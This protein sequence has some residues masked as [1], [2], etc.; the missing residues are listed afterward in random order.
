MGL[1]KN[2]FKQT[3]IY[4]LATVLPRM[5][6]FLLVP[7]Y[8]DLLPK[9]EYGKV[10]IIFAWM[11]FFNVILAY[12]METAFFRF[13]NKEEDKKIVVE[14]SMVSIFWTTIVFLF[15]AL[16]FRTTLADWSGIDSQYIT[17][18]IWILTLDAL[19]IIPFSKLR[20]FQ[21]PM[22]Y[23]IIKIGNVL[24]NLLLS[25]LFLIYLPKMAE[26]NPTGLISSFYIENFQVGYIFLA[27]I[28]ASLLTFV[29]LSPD[30]V[31]LK[32]KFNFSLWK[33]MMVYGLPILVAGIAFAINEQ[34]DKI[35]LDRLLPRNIAEDEVGVYSACYK[36]GLFMVLYRTAYTLGIEPFFFSHAKDENAPQT[37]A[38]VTKYFVIF[39]SFIMLSVIVFADLFKFIMIRDESY[40]VAMKVVPLIILANFCL[41]IYTNLSVWYKLID[42]TYIGAYISIVGA[43]I[44]LV[45]NF[46]LIPSMSYTGSA[47]A[48][49]AAYGSMMLISY[50]LGNKYYPIPYDFNKIGGYLGL[51]VIF[52]VVSFYGFRENYFVG[53][54]LLLLFLYFIYHNEKETLMSIMNRKSNQKK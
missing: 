52:S 19:V 8:T 3:A 38:M 40:W 28:I 21:R 10:T 47:I 11:I 53:I 5:F 26:L 6:S 18:T 33:K 31:F 32:W 24:V 44:T 48:T 45:L 4:G 51:S 23:A 13:Y 7:L 43:I 15:V 12:G 41:G 50:Y 9:A 14:T 54:A 36:L 1:Y 2:L 25:I 37:Y 16:L 20:A 35:L 27:N 30:Y 34:F 39:G 17:Y 22:M 46:L 42:K 29:V 49:L